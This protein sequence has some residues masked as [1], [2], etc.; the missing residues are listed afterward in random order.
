MTRPLIQINDE[1]REMTEEEYN[2]HVLIAGKVLVMDE[3]S[4]EVQAQLRLSASAKLAALGLT[5]EE[6]KAIIGGA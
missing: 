3:E 1:V 4:I 5:E 6:I 2:K